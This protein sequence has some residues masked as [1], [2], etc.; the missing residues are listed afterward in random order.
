MEGCEE[1]ERDEVHKVTL[2]NASTH[3]WAVMVLV[4][5]ADITGATVEGPWWPEDVASR[6]N[7]E[8]HL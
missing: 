3:P 7:G 1:E 6:A 8:L 2:S 4:F 5:D